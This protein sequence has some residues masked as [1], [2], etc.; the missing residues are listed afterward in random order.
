M[1]A[2]LTN[3]KSSIL[4]EQLETMH[5]V[6]LKPSLSNFLNLLWEIFFFSP[7]TCFLN[8]C[9]AS[10]TFVQLTGTGWRSSS[11]S[12]SSSSSGVHPPYLDAAFFLC[13]LLRPFYLQNPCPLWCRSRCQNTDFLAVSRFFLESSISVF[14]CWYSVS[15]C[16]RDLLAVSRL[17]LGS[18]FSWFL[19]WSSISCF[20]LILCFQMPSLAVEIGKSF[21]SL[22]QSSC[23]CIDF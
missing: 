20:R 9:H 23:S 19:C 1:H 3:P 10:Q 14:V 22:E 8:S 2:C 17:F 6:A 5:H 13:L 21:K 4:F 15:R 18:S 7:E 12:S 16:P 11:S